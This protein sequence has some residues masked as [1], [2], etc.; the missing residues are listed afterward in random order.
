MQT[1][2]AQMAFLNDAALWSAARTTLQQEQQHRLESLHDKQ[3]RGA[4]TSSEQAEEQPLVKLYRE[5]QLVR[6]HAVM[7]LMQR[8]YD[9]SDPQ[10][11]SPVM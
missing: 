11:F 10:F 2:L 1:A 6:A 4:L 7:L 8:G 5:T 9:V 3:Q